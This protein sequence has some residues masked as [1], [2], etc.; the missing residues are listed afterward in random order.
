MHIFFLF[1]IF[2][3]IFSALFRI[4]SCIS[5]P[6]LHIHCYVLLFHYLILHKF[7]HLSGV[8]R[9]FDE[10]SK[11]SRSKAGLCPKSG[12][13]C[14]AQGPSSFADHRGDSSG[15]DLS[16]GTRTLL[17]RPVLLDPSFPS[18]S[19]IIWGAIHQV[20]GPDLLALGDPIFV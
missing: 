14:R 3:C 8:S 15:W 17:P 19:E 13:L 10:F 20:L 1:C 4:F 9:S 18:N 6:I 12:Q 2:S 11:S 5:W 16:R 7:V